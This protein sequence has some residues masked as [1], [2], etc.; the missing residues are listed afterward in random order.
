MA[1]RIN[2]GPVLAVVF[3]GVAGVLA[4]K[5][6]PR[7]APAPAPV[8]QP[9]APPAAEPAP[10]PEQYPIEAVPVVPEEASEPLPALEDSDPVA[11]AALSA[12]L[13]GGDLAQWLLPT[14]LVQR[15]VTTIDALP[16]RDITRQVYAAR[17]IAGELVVSEAAGT[18]YLDAANFAR[19]DAAVVVFERIDPR[20]L[21]SA[22]VRLYPLFEQAWREIGPPGRR[23]N[24][25]LVEVIDHLLAAPAVQG[26]IALVPAEGRPRWEFA[27]PR[28]EQAS[29]GHKALWRMGP[30][31][32][33]R[34][35]AKLAQLRE[36]LAAQ[37]P[38]A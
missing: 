34:V 28:L 35:K 12:L 6:Y 36:L 38:A 27:D 24:D 2:P 3:L 32:A 22:Y 30:D 15:L 14:H 33:T 1:K 37:R 23:F 26:P 16:R 17:P 5:Y 19:Y 11:W 13:E 8:A 20:A 9:A 4:W 18:R 31:H 10:P 21:V 7:E 29:I 25:R